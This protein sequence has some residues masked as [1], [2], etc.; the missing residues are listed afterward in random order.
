LPFIKQFSTMQKSILVIG[1]TG[2]LGGKVISHLLARDVSV[3]A[4]VRQGS[5][6]GGLE[7]RGVHTIMGDLT[8][9]ETIMPALKNIDAVISTAIGY[10]KRKKGDSLKSV[11]DMGN[12]NLVEALKQANIPRVVFT[13]IL[14]A[15]KARSVPHFWQKKLI[16]D[17]MGNKGVKYV[18]LRPGAFLDQNPRNDFFASGLKKGSLRV[19]GST[20]V[21]WTMVLSD[22]VAKY[23]AMAAL[24]ENIPFGKIDIGMN[25]PMNAEMLAAYA[26]EYTGSPVKVSAI[27]WGLV[28]GSLSL[29]GLFKP[30]MADLKKMFDYFFTGQ[31]VADTA[32]QQKY[33]G[34]VPTVKDSVF[35]YCRAIGLPEGQK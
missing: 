12:R 11:D 10:S 29:M 16:E 13:S 25:E 22:D 26:S 14:T 33:F 2:Y 15:D 20:S 34:E 30:E 28:G 21:K 35:R 3:S 19:I 27:P 7:S 31:Y 9:R 6:T 4:L 1:G 5:D 32:L 24:D 8:E 23:L 17:Y 18:A